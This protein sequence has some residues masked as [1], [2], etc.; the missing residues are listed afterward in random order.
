MFGANYEQIPQWEKWLLKWQEGGDGPH[1]GEAELLILTI[2]LIAART[3]LD[4][5]LSNPQYKR[6]FN[7]TNRVCSRIRHHQKQKHKVSNVE[8]INATHIYYCCECS[9]IT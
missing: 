5:I 2:N 4:G 8:G 6:L 9:D 1:H 3:P 7:I